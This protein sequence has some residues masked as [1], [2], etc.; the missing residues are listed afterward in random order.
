[1]SIPCTSS[2]PTPYGYASQCTTVESDVAG[3]AKLQTSRSGPRECGCLVRNLPNWVNGRAK[4]GAE[5]GGFPRRTELFTIVIDFTRRSRSPP[6]CD[7]NSFPQ[8]PPRMLH[9]VVRV[10]G[11]MH[12]AS[13][14]IQIIKSLSGFSRLAVFFEKR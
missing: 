10:L 6:W 9:D 13:Y 14:D 4:Q 11:I 5:K 1:M 8:D 7:I 12:G 2:L 3:I